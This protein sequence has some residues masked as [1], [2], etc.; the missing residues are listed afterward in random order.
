MAAHKP[1]GFNRPCWKCGE[2]GH[3]ACECESAKVKLEAAKVENN[4][5]EGLPSTSLEGGRTGASDKLSEVLIN[6]SRTKQLTWMP[7]DEESGGEFHEV[8]KSHEEAARVDAKGGE[9]SEE[10]GK[11][12]TSMDETATA[13]SAPNKP[14][15]PPEGREGQATTGNAGASVHQP[16]GALTDSLRRH[17]GAMTSVR[18]SVQSARRADSTNTDHRQRREDAHVEG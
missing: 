4:P 9:V 1:N 5:P 18:N 12:E 7:H 3:K 10:D 6:D 13:V 11:V 2:R 17:D 8:A 16:N 15:M 14:S